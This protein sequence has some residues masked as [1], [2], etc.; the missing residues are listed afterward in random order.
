[1][2]RK[3][4]LDISLKLLEFGEEKFRVAVP[5]RRRWARADKLWQRVCDDFRQR[6]IKEERPQQGRKGGRGR[7]RRGARR[8]IYGARIRAVWSS[9]EGEVSLTAARVC[10][11]LFFD[12]PQEETLPRAAVKRSVACVMRPARG[13]GVYRHPS[14]AGGVWVNQGEVKMLRPF[15]VKSRKIHAK[16]P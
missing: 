3:Q 12:H 2:C 5:G 1:V 13:R 4:S 16:R 14:G 11:A 9:P 15:S 7:V 10:G 6:E 8:W